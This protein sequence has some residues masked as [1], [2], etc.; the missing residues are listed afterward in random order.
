MK[1]CTRDHQVRIATDPVVGL[2]WLKSSEQH[3]SIK[4]PRGP[5]TPR[6]KRCVTRS[7]C[8]RFAQDDGFVGGLE[9]NWL[10]TQK[11]RNRGYPSI[12]PETYRQMVRLFHQSGVSVGTHAIGDHAIDRVVDT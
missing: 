11:T 9:Y 5:S 4:R 8:E 3:G 10:N 1:R 7:I 6:P 12:D 2:R